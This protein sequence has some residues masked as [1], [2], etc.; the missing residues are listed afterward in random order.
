MFSI[1][2]SLFS[3]NT[4]NYKNFPK[5]NLSPALFLFTSTKGAVTN[6]ISAAMNLTLTSNFILHSIQ[7]NPSAWHMASADPP[8]I[9][10]IWLFKG[11]ARI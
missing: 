2:Y 3:Q 11:V 7:S 5:Y 4:Q 1:C 8:G 10:F 9:M 6:Q